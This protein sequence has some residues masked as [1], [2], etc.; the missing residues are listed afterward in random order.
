MGDIQLHRPVLLIL[1]A[2]SRHRAALEWA[3][4]RAERDWGPV[5]LV[6]H[7]FDFTQ[8][9]YYE[10]TMGSDL[11]KCFFAFN[12]LID[13][14]QLVE[15]KHET[16]AWERD[17]KDSCNWPEPRPLNLDP[18]YLTEAKLVLASTKDSNHRLYIGK[19]IYAEQTLHFQGGVWKAHDW[20]YPDYRCDAYH[21]FLTH[22]R[23]Y[24]RRRYRD[25][26]D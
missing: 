11:S 13:Q 10:R 23:D 18:G 1:A 19:G 20:T 4:S 6:S 15:L 26:P 22:C 8:T 2:F 17:Y 5:N 21:A 16:N 25:P 7:D 3:K 12:R 9:R 24:L 14:A